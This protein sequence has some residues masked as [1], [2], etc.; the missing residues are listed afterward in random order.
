MQNLTTGDNTIKAKASVS[1]EESGLNES[2]C[3][4]VF[5]LK[6]ILKS[7]TPGAD[8]NALSQFTKGREYL[9]RAKQDIEVEL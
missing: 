6:P 2:N 9:I 4:I 8:L 7:W 3:E 5:E 1:V